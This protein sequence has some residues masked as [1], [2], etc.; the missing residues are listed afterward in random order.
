[1]RVGFVALTDAAPLIA[2]EALGFYAER[3]LQVEL[4]REIGWATVRDKIIYGELDAAHAPAPMLWSAQ[5]GLNCPPCE[6]LTA[7]VLNLHGNAVTLSQTMWDAGVRDDA[8]LRN[9]VHE[10]RRRQPVTFAVVFPYSSHHLLL[11][12]WLRSAD[13]DP[14][15][16]VRIVVVPPAQ[17]FRNLSAGTIDGFC[18]GEPWNT[19]AIRER[20]GWCRLTSA[21]YTPGHIE[22]VLMVRAAFAEQRAAEHRALLEAVADACVWCDQPENR[23]PLAE[24]LAGPRFL[25][26]A[27]RL[28]APALTGRFGFGHDRTENVPDFHIFHQGG[29][30]LPD[31]GK[32]EALQSALKAAGLL[33]ADTDPHLPRQLFRADLHRELSHPNT[34]DA[35]VESSALRG[36]SGT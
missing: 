29:A 25:N 10:R 16:D 12:D 21:Q 35:L 4:H 5:L 7:F 17:M 1:L 6:V 23:E 13:I 33:P 30:N 2:A 18:A 34:H 20:I 24:M 3:G 19:L 11:R 15:R 32:A 14:D 22:K 36:V 31:V 27:T 8:A 28:I 9:L 26:M